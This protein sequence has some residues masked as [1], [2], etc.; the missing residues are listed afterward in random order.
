MSQIIAKQDLSIILICLNDAH[1]IEDMLSSLK[2]SDY[3]EL[4]IADGGSSDLTVKIAQKYTKHVYSTEKGMLNQTLKG[5]EEAKGKFIFLAEADHIYPKNFPEKLLGELVL[6]KFDGLQGALEHLSKENFFAMGHREFY[7]IHCAKK[8]EREIIAC[9]QIWVR[10]QLEKLLDD[11]SYGQGFSFD[12]QRAETCK[13]LNLKVGMG[14][15]KAFEGGTVDFARFK[16]RARNYG[17]GDYDF[18]RSNSPSWSFFRKIKSI[19]HIGRQYWF[20]NPAKSFIH[21]NPLIAIPYLYLL[22]AFRYYFWLE[23]LVSE[24]FKK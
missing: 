3:K 9:P 7:K 10:S 14:H 19:T 18:Y 15:T 12:T 22:G 1:C 20:K 16:S 11:M 13:K 23:K 6:T 8:G 24:R 2:G 21:C 17:Y 5:L 4:I